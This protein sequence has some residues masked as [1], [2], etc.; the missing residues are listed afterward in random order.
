MHQAA[1]GFF[2]IY[3][4]YHLLVGIPGIMSIKITR[5]LAYKLY[6]LRLEENLDLK[7]QYALKCLGFYALYTAL[8]C[9]IGLTI[10]DSNT[11]AKLLFAL[12]VLTLLRALGR[13]ISRDLI[14]NAFN[15]KTDRNKFHVALNSI[16]AAAM[17]FVAYQL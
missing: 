14:Q 11:K 17:F 2:L 8:L 5:A 6:K 3:F 4:L 16:L 13:L 7:Y 9:Y 10:Q 12:G 1:D 15:L